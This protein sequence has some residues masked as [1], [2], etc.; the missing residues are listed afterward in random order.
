MNGGVLSSDS[1]SISGNVI[2]GTGS[3]TIAPGGIGSIGTLSVGGLT[4]SSL[5]TLNFDLGSG[6]GVVTSGDLLVL[7]SGT[8]SIASGTHLSFG[9]SPVGGDDYRLIGGSIGGITLGNLSLPAAS[10]G[11]TYALSTSVDTGYID[12]VVTGGGPVS[13]TWNDASADNLW[14]TTSSNWNNGSSTTTFSNGAGVTFNDNNG[15]NYNVTLNSTVAPAS[16]MVNNS[17]GNYAISGTGSISGTA[18]LTK[19]GSGNLTLSTVNGYTGGTTVNQGT[20]VVGVNGALPAGAVSISN[21]TVQLGVSTGAATITSLAITG[22]GTFDVNN[23]HLIINYGGGSDPVAS[24]AALLKTGYNGGHWNGAGGIVS[25][26]AA[27]NS[28]N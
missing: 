22:N 11:E 25:T 21:G 13:L 17:S 5:T 12:L 9:G 18:A 16:V 23:D 2:A 6:S 8:V 1:G 27:A 7:G 26:A 3:H 24:I 4:S 15:G 28:T 19:T 14:N 20:L 10:G